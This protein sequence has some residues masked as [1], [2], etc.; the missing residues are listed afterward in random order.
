MTKIPR[1]DLESFDPEL[2]VPAVAAADAINARSSRYV[3][4]CASDRVYWSVLIGASSVCAFTLGRVSSN[5][6]PW[7]SALGIAVMA[8]AVAIVH[9]VTVTRN[10]YRAA[11]AMAAGWATSEYRH[12]AVMR[13]YQ[14]TIAMYQSVQDDYQ[15]LAV[16]LLF[17]D[18]DKLRA[19]IIAERG[20]DI[21]PESLRGAILAATKS[22][23][24][25]S[26]RPVGRPRGSRVITDRSK[27]LRAVTELER[28]TGKRPTQAETAVR[29]NISVDT[30]RR[31]LDAYGLRWPLQSDDSEA[32]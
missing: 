32:A 12:T 31:T 17:A 25:R 27:I 26:K 22:S 4:W 2:R 15:G 9:D 8:V 13:E 21:D 23:G 6:G 20:D 18:P 11:V 10:R 19:A 7:G 14:T 1:Y 5:P 24:K 3:R 29:L 30:L 28:E 16:E